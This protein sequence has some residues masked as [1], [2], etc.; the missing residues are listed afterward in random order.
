[1][2]TNAKRKNSA[3]KKLI[4]AAG[5]LAL[6]ASMLATSTYAWFTMNQTV[7]VTG[8]Q[9][10]TTVSSNLLIA[11]DTNPVGTAVKADNLFTTSDTSAIAAWLEPVSSNDGASTNFW[12][13]LDALG[14]GAKS[15]S[16]TYIDYDDST[17]GGLSAAE[18]ASTYANK[19]SQAYGVDKTSVAAFNNGV[20]PDDAAQGY[21]D[22]VCQLRATNT[23]SSSQ[24]IYLTDLTLKYAGSTDTDK[25][26]RAAIFMDKASSDSTPVYTATNTLKAIYS[27]A[28]A[29]YQ[30]SG[31]A[32][33]TSN[34]AAALANVSNLN[35]S[36]T[37]TAFATL[38]AGETAYYRVVVRI[39][40][41]GEDKTCTAS[42]FAT[43]NQ[44]WAASLKFDLGT[45]SSG[46]VN[47]N[48]PVANLK[49]DTTT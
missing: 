42:T 18:N 44:N 19:F 28:S 7:T 10:K 24:S 38:N 1:M 41:E 23:T 29:E 9:L 43:L 13:T 2:K 3:V 48:T 30:T 6:S 15:A 36:Q 12:Y 17:N 34:N 5:M 22:Y 49:M 35:A 37:T 16:G 47:D 14:N 11:P 27:P 25:A 32:V 33:G 46:T 45:L 8:M 40:I 39:W 31:Q 26:F 4:P 21:V 20:S